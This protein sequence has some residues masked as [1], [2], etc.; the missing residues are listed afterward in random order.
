MMLF[1]NA[2]R[3]RGKTVGILKKLLLMLLVFLL[4]SACTSKETR[5][6]SRKI[7]A[8]INNSTAVSLKDELAGFSGYTVG[9]TRTARLILKG[10]A[11][12]RD[13]FDM[14]RFDTLYDDLY[15]LVFFFRNTGTREVSEIFNREG[16]PL[17]VELFDLYVFKNDAPPAAYDPDMLILVT[18]AIYDSETGHDLIARAIRDA[19]KEERSIWSVIIGEISADEKKSAYLT[20]VLRDYIPEGPLLVPYL[21]MVN[22]HAIEG[23]IDRHPFASEKG[24][25]VLKALLENTDPGEYNGA[26][27]AA[28]AIPF[29]DRVDRA[30]LLDIA[31]HHPDVNV[32]IEGAWSGVKSGLKIY[33]DLLVLFAKDYRYNW[34]AERY[35]RELGLADMIPPETAEEDFR[36]LA[37]MCG[38]LSHPLEYGAPPDEAVIIDKRTLY[39]PPVK[40]KRS[41]Y[42]I[43]YTYKNRSGD[44]PDETGIGCV[45]SKTYALFGVDGL[46]SM[47]PPELYALF[48]NLESGDEDWKNVEKGLERLKKQNNV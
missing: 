11:H 34:K 18:C 48:S 39:W 20:N 21:D 1:D 36:A 14:S 33:A 22:L 6:F 2:C 26:V 31:V 28:T 5:L 12:I 13:N 43:R 15:T 25:N 47:T 38:W 42:L 27:S 46:L 4:A 45:G 17:L 44:R 16:I 8:W 32:M 23:G 19:Y 35:L 3:G 9:D 41:M 29:L 10:L 24:C 37:E 30:F 7:E 40:E